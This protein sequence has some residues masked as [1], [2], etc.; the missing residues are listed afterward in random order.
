MNTKN[1]SNWTPLMYAA[2]LGHRELCQLLIMKGASVDETN[3]RNQTAVRL[4][5]MKI[6]PPK[7]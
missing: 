2:Y 7:N 5:K 6:I 4:K 3:E 1:S